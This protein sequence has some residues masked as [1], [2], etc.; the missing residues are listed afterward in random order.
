MKKITF[1]LLTIVSISAF[2]QDKLTSAIEEYYDGTNW[3]IQGKTEYTYDTQGNVVTETYYDSN[4]DVTD[5]T[6]YTYNS[7]NRL[8][9]VES[10]Y[11]DDSYKSEFIYNSDNLPETIIQYDKENGNW[12]KDDKIEVVY[13]GTKIDY[14]VEYEEWNG[15]EWYL[16]DDNSYKAKYIYTNSNFTK[17]I[18]Y[19]YHNNIWVE[20]DKD[21]YTYDASNK[22]IKEKWFSKND[23]GTYLLGGGIEYS[24]DSNNNIIEEG[25][26]EYTDE[27]TINYSDT[28]T[29]QYDLNVKMKDIIH[30]FKD[31]YGVKID[32][33]TSDF[34]V[35]K[36]LL[37]TDGSNR[38]T[39]YYNG[40]T[41][42]VEEFNAFAFKIYPNP[43]SSILNIDDSSFS[44]KSVEVYNLLGKK[45]ITTTLNEVN[46]EN[47]T[48]GIYMLRVQDINGNFATKRFV[49]N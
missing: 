5:T 28:T 33:E 18:Y 49:K 9:E 10:I 46:I 17:I 8:I 43:T 21:E 1:L 44:I 29:Y 41:A 35:N 3:L 7:L 23:D 22:L 15:E 47:I 48:N 31:K 42:S 32:F 45:I 12:V 34:Y 39:Y 38:T 24:Y 20:D 40:D 4:N 16:E 27:G 36:I 11:G 14:Y 37:E 19:E 25:F 13:N 30:P 6:T 26:V 2:G